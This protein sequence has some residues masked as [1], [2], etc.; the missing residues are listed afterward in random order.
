MRRH[1]IGILRYGRVERLL[2]RKINSGGD[3]PRRASRGHVKHTVKYRQKKRADA[4]TLF[5]CRP[6]AS[7]AISYIIINILRLSMGPDTKEYYLQLK[8]STLKK[9]L[10][11][12]E[13]HPSCSWPQSLLFYENLKKTESHASLPA[14]WSSSEL[15]D[16]TQF[17][18]P[19][20]F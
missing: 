20:F 15:T 19:S 12:Y 16:S 8:V 14:R 9:Q 3:I 13:V 1:R 6:K 10:Y 17:W 4:S 5:R 18:K 11:S 2:N 7:T